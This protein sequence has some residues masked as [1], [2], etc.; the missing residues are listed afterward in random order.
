MFLQPPSQSKLLLSG[1]FL[2]RDIPKQQ[3]LA[4]F[5]YAAEIQ[6]KVHWTLLA[7][8]VDKPDELGQK[9]FLLIKTCSI[10]GN[11]LPW[12]TSGPNKVVHTFLPS[13]SKSVVTHLRAGNILSNTRL[14]VYM[15]DCKAARQGNSVVLIGMFSICSRKGSLHRCPRRRLK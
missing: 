7:A 14:D 8:R 5:Q 11:P 1:M 6:D 10:Q 15:R 3:L 2:I 12:F 4:Y 13:K 9:K